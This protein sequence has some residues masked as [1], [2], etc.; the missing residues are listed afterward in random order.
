M[1][2][3]NTGQLK[4]PGR[5]VR[6]TDVFELWVPGDPVAKGRPRLTTNAQ[7]RPIAYTP[8]KT[9]DYEN[10]VGYFAFQQMLE[11]RIER[12]TCPVSLD[13]VFT[14]P[15]PSSWSNKRTQGAIAGRIA[16]TKKPD[17]DNLEKLI[18]DALNGVLWTDDKLVI[19]STKCKRYGPNP[20]VSIKVTALELELA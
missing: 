19:E 16:H 1:P 4:R 3:T 7:G 15:I 20:G 6:V 14:L 5:C 11:Q 10:K 8:A 2:S 9:K 12:L 18:K 13:L 17:L